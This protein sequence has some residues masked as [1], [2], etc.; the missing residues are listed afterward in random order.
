MS[1]PSVV[2][3]ISGF[4]EVPSDIITVSQ[5]IS[6]SEPGIS[7]GLLLPEASGSPSS[8]LIMRIP[9]TQP[10]SSTRISVGFCSRSKMIPSSFAWC[11]SS[12]RAGS[13]SSPRRYTIWVSAPRRSAVLAAS[14]ATFPPPTTTTFFPW[15][16]G[17]SYSS[18]KA[19]IRLFLVKNSL[20]ENT[21]FAC[22]PGIPINLGS[23]APEPIN[24]ASNP[25]SAISSSILTDLPMTTLVSILTPNALTFST[26]AATTLSFGRRNSG[27][28]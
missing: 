15:K 26:S 28:P 11:T 1:S 2:E 4:G 5:S 18:S 14:M 21:P 12:L 8:I 20:A 13:S 22:S 9:F 27:I 23:P 17:V 24:T 3:E 7:T 10:F 25:S 19:F 16:I 6:Y